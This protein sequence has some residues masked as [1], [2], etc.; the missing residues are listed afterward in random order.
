VE[1]LER[2]LRASHR[3]RKVG[4]NRRFALIDLERSSIVKDPVALFS[5]EW[6]GRADLNCR[7]LAPQA[8][9]LPG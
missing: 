5:E 3:R 7:P 9:A 8:S 6:S 4:E 1:I 2:G